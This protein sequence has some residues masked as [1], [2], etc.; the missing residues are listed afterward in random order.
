[1]KVI[2]D[3]RL[4]KRPDVIKSSPSRHLFAFLE[5]NGLLAPSCKTLFWEQTFVCSLGGSVEELSYLRTKTAD[6]A[7]SSRLVM[8]LNDL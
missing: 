3:A 2:S 6:N 7:V 1:M 5:R 4:L 8:S